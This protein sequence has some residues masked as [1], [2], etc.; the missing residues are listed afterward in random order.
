MVLSKAWLSVPTAAGLSLGK[1]I[2]NKGRRDYS[3]I[4]GKQL[5]TIIQI[6][7]I[8]D[9]NTQGKKKQVFLGGEIVS[10][11]PLDAFDKADLGGV[12]Y[13]I[14]EVN[15]QDNLDVRLPSE[16]TSGWPGWEVQLPK[17]QVVLVNSKLP[18]QAIHMAGFKER[19]FGSAKKI[20]Q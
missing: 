1:K 16:F 12:N 7:L 9:I 17:L 8:W 6:G 13:L 15:L 18:R 11:P 10:N 2:G 5:S 4:V 19:R 20:L 14:V 3:A